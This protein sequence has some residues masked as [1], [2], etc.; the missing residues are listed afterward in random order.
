MRRTMPLSVRTPRASYTAC[1]EIAPLS[2][3][4]I[5]SI[6]SAVRC[7]ASETARRTARRWA[8][9]WTP[10][11]RSCAAWSTGR[12]TDTI[13]PYTQYWTSSRR[14]SDQPWPSSRRL[15]AQP[16]VLRATGIGPAQPGGGVEMTSLDQTGSTALVTGASRGFGRAIAA[17]LHSEG[18]TV[19]AVAR[20]AE[21]LASLR[22][23][24]GDRLVPEIADVTDPVVAGTLLEQY[25][26][27]TLVLN[28]GASPL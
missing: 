27:D 3:R 6:S 22:R 23:E 21:L 9:T 14:G 2:G 4:T 19:V 20:H 12:A 10:C 8:V 24:L 26:P 15:L 7:G 1:R 5:L 17:A 16:A 28:A 13:G 11:W 25:Q 18:A